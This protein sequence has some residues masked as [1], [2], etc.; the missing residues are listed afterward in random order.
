MSKT[1]E[2]IAAEEAATKA[3]EEEAARKAAEGADDDEKLREGGLKALKAERERAKALETELAEFK[4]VQKER[5]DA[6]KTDLEKLQEANS[7]LTG[8]LTKAQKTSVL[9]EIALDKG[10]TKA[11]VRRLV[12]ETKEELEADAD[13]LLEELGV[14]K[15]ENDPRTRTRELRGGNKPNSNAGVEM[16]PAKL[17]EGVRQLRY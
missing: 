6:E 9:Y 10:L 11:Q 15:N 4:R 2:E 7:E 8:N 13:E 17:A 16:D 1:P 5:E 12:G 14:S 3:A